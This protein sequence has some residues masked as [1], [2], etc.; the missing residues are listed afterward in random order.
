LGQ[1]TSGWEVTMS[2]KMTKQEQLDEALHALESVVAGV[3]QTLLH[4]TDLYQNN[5]NE[6][7]ALMY[8]VEWGTRVVVD[9]KN[10]G[11]SE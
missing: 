2:K 6:Y 10:G 7:Y 4:S 9:I 8:W 3:R 1:I 5:H 11:N